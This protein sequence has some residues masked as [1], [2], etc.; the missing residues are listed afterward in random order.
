M[1]PEKQK[2]ADLRAQNA[3]PVQT[4]TWKRIAL[5]ALPA[6]A[7]AA[8]GTALVAA[9]PNNVPLWDNGTVP[10]GLLAAGVIILAVLAYA[11][12]RAFVKFIENL[13]DRG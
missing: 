3:D 9:A 2:R 1:T 8:L 5:A 4:P 6:L 7:L 11:A 12:I 10:N 13:T